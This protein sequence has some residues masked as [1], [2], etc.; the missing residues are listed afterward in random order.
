MPELNIKY[1]LKFVNDDSPRS[2]DSR[3]DAESALEEAES[4]GRQL[5]LAW[6]EVGDETV[7]LFV[8]R[9]VHLDAVTPMEWKPTHKVRIVDVPFGGNE[10]KV[11]VLGDFGFLPE[12]W[13]GHPGESPAAFVKRDGVW[14]YHGAGKINGLEEI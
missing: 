2:F 3:K 8:R 11:M 4:I 13:N 9:S 6:F 10:L 14:H 1:F 5:V 7:E 12:C